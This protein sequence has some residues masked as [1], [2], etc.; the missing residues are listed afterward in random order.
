[1]VS[2]TKWKMEIKVVTKKAIIVLLPQEHAN[3]N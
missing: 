1:M 3:L 2:A